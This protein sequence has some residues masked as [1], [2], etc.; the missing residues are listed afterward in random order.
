MK[1][2]SK[3]EIYKKSVKSTGRFC[4]ILAVFLE[5]LNFTIFDFKMVV[6]SGL[7]FFFF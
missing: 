7:I 2:P 6:K 3:F 4:Q 5:I 1:A